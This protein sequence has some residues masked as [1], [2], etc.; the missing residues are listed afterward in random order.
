MFDTADL[1]YTTAASNVHEASFWIQESTEGFDS[2]SS[3]PDIGLQPF[4]LERPESPESSG[5]CSPITPFD[6]ILHFITSS[7]LDYSF[8]FTTS[9]EYEADIS[10]DIWASEQDSHILNAVAYQKDPRPVNANTIEIPKMMEWIAH[11]LFSKSK[12]IWEALHK[13][14]GAGQ[15]G[16]TGRSRLSLARNA[17]F[18]FFTPPNLE[19]FLTSY[20]RRWSSNCPII[21]ES[22][23]ERRSTRPE[24]VMVMALIGASMSSR[25]EVIE[26]ARTWLDVAGE[27][28]FGHPVLSGR[29][30]NVEASTQIYD[31]R[32]KLELLQ[33][34]LLI[35]VLQ[36]WEGEETSRK[37]VRNLQ[38][39]AVTSVGL[40]AIPWVSTC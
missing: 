36:H 34:S 18:K 4:D 2:L 33:S 21:H 1:H 24:L 13:L 5:R 23:F 19:K 22:S 27:L 6:F 8:N 26:E 30:D 35:S 12:S 20:W 39:T 9:S 37:R 17:C 11:P 14:E 7:G 31:E 29:E 40:P 10:L 38:Y 15:D 28:I 16:T 25:T 3:I 32:E